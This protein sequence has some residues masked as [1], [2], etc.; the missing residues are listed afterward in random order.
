MNGK[1]Q[2][3]K[4]FVRRL[5]RLEDHKKKQWMIG[6][7]ALAMTIFVGL[8]LIYIT[9][10]GLPKIAQPEQ[11]A[12]EAPAAGAEES[13]FETFQ[14]GWKEISSQIGKTFRQTENLINDQ[15]AKSNE[16]ILNNSTS[17]PAAGVSTTVAAPTENTTT[18]PQSQ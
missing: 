18:I 16:I 8:W 14:R 7:T 2:R 9:T 5:Q 10:F 17:G 12:K 15:I 13:F 4:E 6:L 3:F 1:I 11:A